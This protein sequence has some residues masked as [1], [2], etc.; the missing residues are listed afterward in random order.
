MTKRKPK[1]RK[2]YPVHRERERKGC[3]ATILPSCFSRSSC[4]TTAP[5]APRFYIKEKKRSRC[6]P[7]VLSGYFPIC[8]PILALLRP[9]P[10]CP[11]CSH[12]L[13][14]TP[15]WFLALFTHLH[16]RRPLIA[17]VEKPWPLLVAV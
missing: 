1:K 17:T 13:H 2:F 7:A 10:S 12:P 15:T 6:P 3:I 4:T 14:A 11:P 8:S 9:F 16:C 5:F